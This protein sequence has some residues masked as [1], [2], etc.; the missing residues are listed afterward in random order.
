MSTGEWRQVVQN[1]GK[2]EIGTARSNPD[3]YI[4][5]KQVS[6]ILEPVFNIYTAP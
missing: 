6:E 1:I 2:L 4:I 5:R 3:G